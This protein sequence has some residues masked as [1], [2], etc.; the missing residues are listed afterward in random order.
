MSKQDT[1]SSI[2]TLFDA[3]WYTIVTITTVGYGDITPGSLLGYHV[4][5]RI[6]R[7]IAGALRRSNKDLMLLYEALI[8]EVHGD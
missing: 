4:M 1:N 3:F 8:D 7:R 6:S 2:N 5:Y